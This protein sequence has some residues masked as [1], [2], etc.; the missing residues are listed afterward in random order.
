M[1]FSKLNKLWIGLTLGLLLPL[2]VFSIYWFIF[3]RNLDI[4]QDDV[5][6]LINKELM[7]NVFKMCCG[8]D[9]VLFYIGLNKRMTD[10]TK[11][12]I[13]SVL[14]YAIVYAFLTFY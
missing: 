6:Y 2:F 8:I 7:M 4:P 5:R 9:L 12:V 13:G 10:F 14:V 3:Q 1:E 11:G